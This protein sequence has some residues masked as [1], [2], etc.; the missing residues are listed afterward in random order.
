MRSSERHFFCAL[1]VMDP[2]EET[3]PLPAC[4]QFTTL[5]HV[6][7]A[8]PKCKVCDHLKAKHTKPGRRELSSGE[9]RAIREKM[10]D[11]SVEVEAAQASTDQAFSDSEPST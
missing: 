5:I 7:E 6:D 4:E 8:D 1:L 10:I 2:F 11:M 3:N 9:I